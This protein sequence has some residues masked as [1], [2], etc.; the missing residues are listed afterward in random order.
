MSGLPTRTDGPLPPVCG[1]D[2]PPSATL[3]LGGGG[4]GRHGSQS[5][6]VTAT[7]LHAVPSLQQ[8]HRR[9]YILHSTP[10][11]YP[12]PFTALERIYVSTKCTAYYN[13]CLHE[14][15][16]LS[17]VYVFLLHVTMIST[18][19]LQPACSLHT[20]YAC[21]KINMLPSTSSTLLAVLRL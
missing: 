8:L 7:S 20:F 1:S 19:H 14:S 9:F 4:G 5:I 18:V 16:T 2:G 12:S 13:T 21:S 15:S 6:Y 3:C 17:T 11:K 10:A